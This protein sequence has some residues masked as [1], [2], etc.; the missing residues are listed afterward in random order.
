MNRI[1]YR[2]L[3]IYIVKSFIFYEIDDNYVKNPAYR[4]D[5]RDFFKL[6]NISVVSRKQHENLNCDVLH[7]GL[8]YY[9]LQNG[10]CERY[11]K[12]W[13]HVVNGLYL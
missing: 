13:L 6:R 11:R 3:I 10:C 5:K 2:I 8:C 12:H 7:W 9:D 4:Y 1:Y